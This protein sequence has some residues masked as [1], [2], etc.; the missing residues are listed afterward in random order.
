VTT[1]NE[2]PQPEQEGGID[3]LAQVV[4]TF[5]PDGGLHMK[6]LGDLR[7]TIAWAMGE[8]MRSVGDDMFQNAKAQAREALEAK[9]PRLVVPQGGLTRIPR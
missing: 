1:E 7:P 6:A 9:Q 3:A 8:F 2:T 4:L 5:L